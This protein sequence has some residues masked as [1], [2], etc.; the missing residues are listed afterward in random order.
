MRGDMG[1]LYDAHA[2]RLYAYCWS[3]VGDQLAAA[4]VGDAF[5]AAVHQPPRGDTVLWL[6]SLSRSACAERGA[7]AGNLDGRG[8]VLFA[9]ADPLLRAAAALRPD[10]REVLLLWAGEWLEPHDIARV[11]GIAPDTVRQLLDAAR[12]R[13]ERSVLD[14]LMR[15]TTEARHDLIT[16][17]EKKRLPQLLARRAPARAPGWLRDQVLATCEDEAVRPLPSVASP[18]PLVVIGDGRPRRG[19]A[20]DRARRG[21]SGGLHRGLGAAA[22]VAASAAAVI[23]LL[24]AWP[25]PKGGGGAATIVPTA[26]GAGANPASNATGGAPRHPMPGLS[27]TERA[28]GEPPGSPQAPA[29]DGG[30]AAAPTPGGVPEGG[31]NPAP[32]A[33]S[34]AGTPSKDAQRSVPGTPSRP[35]A[36]TTPPPT[37]GSPSPTTPPATPGDPTTPPGTGDP[38][39]PPPATPSD[40]PS[41]EPGD[42]DSGTPSPSPTSNPAPSPSGD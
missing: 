41:D 9:T 25:S 35:D 15:G 1:S 14:I 21:L 11:L 26:S 33:T 5:T 31:A 36:P 8:G 24:A 27:G 18:S 2:D 34:P 3:L 10:H 32:P 4:A 39:T 19:T 13:L 17:F 29:S 40:P 20:A 28:T 23:G 12:A 30:T 7:F 22:G 6:Y 42:G 16:A 38:T 37:G